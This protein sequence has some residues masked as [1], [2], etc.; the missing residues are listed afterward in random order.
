MLFTFHIQLSN[1]SKPTVWRRITVPAN[2]TFAQFHHVIQVA[3]G[4]MNCHLYSFSEKRFNSAMDI[5]V[6]F[7][8]DDELGQEVVSP[9][10]IRLKNIFPEHKSYLYI[11]DFGDDWKHRIK[12]EKVTDENAKNAEIIAGKG[13]CP[14]E[15]CGGPWGYERLKMSV[16]NPGDDEYEEFR[17]WL[18]LEEGELY[19]AKEFDIITKKE[20]V[21]SA[22]LN[23]RYDPW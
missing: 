17:E 1:I 4:W 8:T 11:Y 19:D 10:K 16:N 3:F 12:L 23:I 9:E 22:H 15:D 21:R 7:D 2:F 6:P 13:K 5:Q 14:P 20:N 18:S